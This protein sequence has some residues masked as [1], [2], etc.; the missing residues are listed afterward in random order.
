M[1]SMSHLY[2]FW[3]TSLKA[4]GLKQICQRCR[5]WPSDPLQRFLGF[6]KFYRCFILNFS[7]VVALLNHLTST[8]LRFAWSEE[9]EQAFQLIKTLF[10]APSP[11][12]CPGSFCSQ[13]GVRGIAWD[14]PSLDLCAGSSFLEGGGVSLQCPAHGLQHPSTKLDSRFPNTLFWNPAHPGVLPGQT[15]QA[16]FLCYG[17]D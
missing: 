15:W 6:A 1:P 3:G 17:W 8:K 4:G 9:A 7:H 2:H 11:M 14:H 5:W 13:G 12:P 10:T 16:W